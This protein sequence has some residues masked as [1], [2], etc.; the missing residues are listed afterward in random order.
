MT[1]SQ[2]IEEVFELFLHAV[3]SSSELKSIQMAYKSL[4]DW[5]NDRGA[6]MPTLNT[7]HVIRH[8]P[9]GIYRND[10]NKLAAE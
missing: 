2:V 3:L 7:R 9:A 5:M 6:N 8:L 10:E 1:V 4:R